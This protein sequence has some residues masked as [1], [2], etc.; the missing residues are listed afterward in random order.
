MVL[1]DALPVAMRI[2]VS[3]GPYRV[4][5]DMDAN[6]GEELMIKT[7]PPTEQKPYNAA[8]SSMIADPGSLKMARI[9]PRKPCLALSRLMT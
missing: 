6:M 1:R 4:K 7:L 8:T 5:S 3:N 2:T 9:G